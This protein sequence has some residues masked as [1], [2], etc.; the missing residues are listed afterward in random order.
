MNLASALTDLLRASVDVGHGF[1]KYIK[2][3]PRSKDQKRMSMLIYNN[4]VQKGD[5]VLA[6]VDTQ[7]AVGMEMIARSAFEN[8]I[9]LINLF[10]HRPEYLQ[11]VKYMS[12]LQQ[13]RSIDSLIKN[14]QS[15]FSVPII[16]SMP[17]QLGITI[18]QS[19]EVAK[20]EK[21]QF[22]L[23]LSRVYTDGNK[24]ISEP[25]S[26]INTSVRL[27][28]ELAGQKDKYESLYRI[29]SRSTHSDFMSMLKGVFKDG[30]YVWPPDP[31]QPSLLVIDA[32]TMMLHETT[33][34]LAKKLRKPF[35][36]VN[37]LIEERHRL[38]SM[39]Q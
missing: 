1:V 38:H 15:P 23:R 18:E 27:R 16:R 10:K 29:L 7:K 31:P 9:D 35:P 33:E 17:E 13:V 12:S 14:G 3:T 34:M 8:Y 32:V 6:L 24:P 5:S 2:I 26:R 20:E 30:G 28:S 4:L 25:R 22:R 11:Y 37:E 39:R 21:M 19:L 36:A